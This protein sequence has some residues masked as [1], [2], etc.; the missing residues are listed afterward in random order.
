MLNVQNFA[1][2]ALA[3]FVVMFELFPDPVWI[4]GYSWIPWY[5]TLKGN[6]KMKQFKMLRVRG[7]WYTCSNW[8]EKC[9]QDKLIWVRDTCSPDDL[10]VTK[11]KIIRFY[12]ITVTFHSRFIK[13]WAQGNLSAV[14]RT[15]T[16][17]MSLFL[18]S[19][20]SYKLQVRFLFDLK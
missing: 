2:E 5:W 20:E 3:L 7:R 14:C 9:I 6:K 8:Q 16:A 10:E 4:Q 17:K 19:C 12:S 11:F 18:N 13:N 15:K 1:V